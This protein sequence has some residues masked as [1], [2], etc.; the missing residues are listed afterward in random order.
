MWFEQDDYQLK[1]KLN[2]QLFYSC[3]RCLVDIYCLSVIYNN[4]S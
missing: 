2:L 3:N 4:V 1:N